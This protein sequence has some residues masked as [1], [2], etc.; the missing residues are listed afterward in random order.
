MSRPLPHLAGR[1]LHLWRGERAL[2]SGLS[3]EA[4]PGCCIQV[5]GPNGA[6]KTSLLRA[7]CGLLPLER[8]SVLWRGQALHAD[9]C[10]FHAELAYLGHDTGL[11][12][13]LDAIDNLYYE[14]GMRRRVDRGQAQAV[15][16][17]IGVA[18]VMHQTIRQMSAG[19]KRRVA[20]ARVLLCAAPLWI[21]DE[22]ASNL[23]AAGQALVGTLLDEHL[24]A[25][26]IA[27]VATH[28]ALAVRGE[29]LQPLVLG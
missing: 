26:G 15:L 16:E 17:R 1:D 2:L 12:N 21:L 23:D 29:M 7:L 6:G 28:H 18:H 20:F 27:V 3:F 8:G 22:P 25:G 19:Q 13:D 14:V 9:R 24:A 5:T 11:K 10:A 4:G